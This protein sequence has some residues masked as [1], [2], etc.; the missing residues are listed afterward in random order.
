MVNEYKCI[1]NVYKNSMPIIFYYDELNEYSVSIPIKVYILDYWK[2]IFTQMIVYMYIF[3][4]K[5]FNSRLG[6]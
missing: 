3:I 1:Y 5:S 2:K 4:N 6:I